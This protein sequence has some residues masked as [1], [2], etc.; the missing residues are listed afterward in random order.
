MGG[1]MR[2]RKWLNDSVILVFTLGDR[3]RVKNS[4]RQIVWQIGSRADI[5][6][7]CDRQRVEGC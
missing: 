5:H 1:V 3:G 7:E 2:D 4:I 6:K